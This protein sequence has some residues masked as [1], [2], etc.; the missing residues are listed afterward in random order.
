[1]LEGLSVGWADTYAAGLSGQQIN[2]TGLPRGNYCL[3]SDADPDNKF[4]ESDDSNNAHR[5]KIRLNPAKLRVR[6]LPE[7]CRGV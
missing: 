4:A 1:M 5:L 7:P 6:P 3:V 2:V